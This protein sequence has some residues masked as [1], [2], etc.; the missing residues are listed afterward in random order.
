MPALGWW[1]GSYPA[2]A[3]AG[4]AVEA[5]KSAGGGVKIGRDGSIDWLC[6]PR[7][8]SGACFAALLHDESAGHWRRA[9]L[10]GCG[11]PA[12]VS[13]RHLDHGYRVGHP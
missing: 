7:F 8:D 3:A 6:L 5:V 1:N 9:R 12:R 11:Y 4:T 13:R 10:R 2:S